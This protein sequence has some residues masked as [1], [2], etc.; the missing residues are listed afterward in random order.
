[1]TATQ[2]IKDTLVSYLSDNSPDDSITVADANT[3]AEIALPI[4]AV[5]IQSAA[6]HSVALCMVT[7]A[8]VAIT[9][10]AH[11]GDEDDADIPTW[12]DQIESLFFDKSAM[13]DVLNQSEVTVYD[14]TYNGST[15]TWDESSL[16]V[17]FT[18][19]VILQRI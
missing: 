6:A 10:R 16:E 11:A 4:L 18:A 1:M 14:W 2:R 19:A 3:R 5:D 15:Q 8:E 12:I 13:L 7:T 17:S 9:L